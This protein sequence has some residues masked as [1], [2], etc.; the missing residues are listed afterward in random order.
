ML[1]DA[2]RGK[3]PQQIGTRNITNLVRHLALRT[4]KKFIL[5]YVRAAFVRLLSCRARHGVRVLRRA[6]Q[7]A[8]HQ[9]AS[10]NL[11]PLAKIIGS[12]VSEL[13]WLDRLRLVK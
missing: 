5:V 7:L 13:P 4:A 10:Q 12:S 9:A 2:T 6:P 1:L 3:L 8:P 11:F